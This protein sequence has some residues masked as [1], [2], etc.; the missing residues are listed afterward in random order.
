[1][2]KVKSFCRNCVAACGMD[3][4]IENNEI[5]S[6][7]GDRDNPLTNGYKCIKGQGAVE[8]ARNENRL[9]SS[10]KR[11]ADGSFV[12]IDSERASIEIG[13]QLRSILEQ[14]G[15]R[16]I[17]LY[18][19]TAGHFNT[20]GAVIA[21]AFL[22]AAGSPN[23]FTSM[24]LDQSAKYVTIGR[25]G[26]FASGK[27]DLEDVDAVMMVGANPLVTHTNFLV[28][29]QPGIHIRKARE[30]GTRLVVVDPR[31]S[32]TARLADLHLKVRPGEDP[33]LFA[34][35]IRHILDRNLH[36]EEFCSRYVENLD[37]L[38]KSVE[39]FT[40][41]Y[42]AER[43]GVPAANISKAAEIFATAK[44]KVAGS[45][46]GPNMIKYCNLAEHLIESLN[47]ICGAYRRAGDQIRNPGV[48]MPRPYVEMVVPPMRMWEMEPQL[49][50][51][52]AGYLSGEF[53]SA[54]LPEEILM[55][56]EGKIRALIV[57]GGNPLMALPDT[58]QAIEAMQDLDLLVCL[59][60]RVT[61]TSE[62]A[63]Y[64]I[65]PTV[66]FERHDLTAVGDI[67][68]RKPYVQYSAPV[69]K[70]P[71]GVIDDWE[72]FWQIC[73]EMDL[74]PEV[75]PGAPI[76]GMSYDHL[77]EGNP[78]DMKDKPDPETLVRDYLA[79]SRI[80]LD[81]LQAEPGGILWDGSAEHIVPGDPTSTDRL[82][83]APYDVCAEL[84]SYMAE[85]QPTGFEYRLVVRRMIEVMNSTYID[86]TV[87]KKRFP[88]NYLYMN[89]DDMAAAGI[90]D[91]AMVR[92]V[93]E[94][95][96]LCVLAKADKGQTTG[97][98]SISHLWGKSQAR[99]ASSPD[100][101]VENGGSHG[102]RLVGSELS[103]INFM[104]QLTN[105][106][107]NISPA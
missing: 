38:R 49:R 24:T 22:S 65:A 48:I 97:V 5:I 66:S 82:D 17:G 7:S 95:G 77:P 28:A 26:H 94:H 43:S 16:S 31:E 40:L 50:S 35:I 81:Q 45:S 25:L 46:T 9:L 101:L 78:I 29:N 3:L 41:E 87:A 73:H 75:K 58:E 72:F 61:G 60:P 39:P 83:V 68:F 32:E 12:E 14:Y 30:R 90:E 98:V 79:N 23:F 76:A 2:A 53:P 47:A 104:P 93:S 54:L 64:I 56:G 100:E 36:D 107:V 44:R 70:K 88:S 84:G 33:A 85:Q 1:M 51:R 10:L 99:L 69:L 80:S 21:K 27:H 57:Y 92:V 55:P 62:F 8:F 89:E 102:A 96:E 42:A 103:G 15:P 37:A 63:D 6:Y 13:Q 4:K 105:I 59:D 86:S 11:N 19:G 106:P 74:S 18:M 20:L 52:N 67:T 71:E 91:K 34:G